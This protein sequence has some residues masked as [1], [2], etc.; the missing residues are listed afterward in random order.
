MTMPPIK[1]LLIEDSPGDIRLIRNA[2]DE[3]EGVRFGHERADCLSTGLARLAKGGI[4]LVL[5]DLS[6][7]DSKGV[8]AVTQVSAQAPSVPCVVLTGCN[9][10]AMGLRALQAGAQDYLVKGAIQSREL[11]RS[12]RYAIGRKRVDEEL[13]KTH[14]QTE[15]LLTSISSILIG[16]SPEGR[17]I[18]WNTVAQAMFGLV[19]TNVLGR[20]LATTGIHWEADR[21]LDGVATC[22]RTHQPT[23]VDNV[24]FTRPD[25]GQGI[26]GLT[27]N[28]ILNSTGVL[29]GCLVLGADITERVKAQEALEVKMKEMELLNRIM[30]G[31]EDRILELK[32]ELKALRAQ[33]GVRAS[34]R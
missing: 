28:P 16:V 31:R 4:D 12:L 13:R 1:V 18:Q 19:S 32:E 27:I 22:Q 17:V 23:R 5:L 24:R 3:A 34:E 9:D 7:P 6:L 25:G 26:V 14:A 20:P 8:E 30:T 11:V 21:V 33:L 10:E 29:T 2:L 15:Q